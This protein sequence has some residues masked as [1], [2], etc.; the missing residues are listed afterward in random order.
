MKTFP[1]VVAARRIFQDVSARVIASRFFRD[2]LSMGLL[3]LAVVLNVVTMAWLLLRVHPNDVPVPVRYSNLLGGFDQLG[4]WYWPFVI[5]GFAL[6]VTLFNAGF[7]YYS[8]HRSRLVSFFLLVTSNVV[9]AF[10]LIV[11]SAFGVVR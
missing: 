5:A 3:G 2:G 9:G 6:S 8:F 10:S 1:P 7:A 11:S 4:P